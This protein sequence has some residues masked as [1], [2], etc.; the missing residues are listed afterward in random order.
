MQHS[1]MARFSKMQKIARDGN[2]TRGNLKKEK[3]AGEERKTM[4]VP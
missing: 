2:L 4:A 1:T 3:I